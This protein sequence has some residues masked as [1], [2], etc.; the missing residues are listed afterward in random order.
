MEPNRE[1][2]KIIEFYLNPKLLVLSAEISETSVTFLVISVSVNYSGLAM[3]TTVHY[4]PNDSHSYFLRSS[5]HPSHVKNSI[6]YSQFLR[7]RRLYSHDSDFIPKSDEMCKF[8][9]EREY[10]S[11]VVTSALEHRQRNGLETH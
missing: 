9:A 10:P 2:G 6:P 5:S 4:Y 7:L 8:F 1:K 11:S 3:P